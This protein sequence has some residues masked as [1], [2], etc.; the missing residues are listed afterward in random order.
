[1]NNA[2]SIKDMA[3]RMIEVSGKNIKLK[4]EEVEDVTKL[5]FR[6]EGT[7]LMDA[8]KLEELGW[9]P[10]YSLDETLLK[11]LNSIGGGAERKIK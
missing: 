10:V 9:K 3:M 11:V 7:T 6:K 5:G 1:M 4:I 2:I 8:T